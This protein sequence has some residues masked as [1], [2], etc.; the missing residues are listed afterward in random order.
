MLGELFPDPFLKYQNWAYLR[1]IFFIL[2]K[3]ED[4]HNILKLNCRPLA[5]T[6]YKGI[7]L[8][9]LPHFGQDIRRKL[10]L[11]LYYITWSNFIVGLHLIHEIL[12]TMCIIIV[13]WPS[14]DV[15]NFEINVISLIKS[16]TCRTKKSRQKYKYLENKKSFSNE[17]KSIFYNF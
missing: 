7:E 9:S 11:S 10:F 12:C 2:C 13:C 14:H 5:I 8:V 3:N 17:I 6:S 16:F 1:I 4:H 15:I